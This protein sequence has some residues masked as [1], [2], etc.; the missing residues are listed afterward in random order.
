MSRERSSGSI[1]PKV[2]A[3]VAVIG[4]MRM[5]ASHKRTHGGPS[6]WRDR[7]R[8]MVAE[9]HRELHRDADAKAGTAEA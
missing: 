9:L 7:R 5:L 2:I 6:S 4:L 1:F 3:V 8:E